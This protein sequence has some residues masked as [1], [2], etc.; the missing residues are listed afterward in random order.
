L[1]KIIACLGIVLTLSISVN[2]Y[3]FQSAIDW[4]EAWLEQMLTTSLVERIYKESG[5][6][7][8][9]E[10]V[11]KLVENEFRYEVVT[12]TNENDS[13]V[14]EGSAAISVDGTIL[15]FTDGKYSGSK[16]D[17]PDNLVHWG[18]GQD[19]F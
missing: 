9:Y 5:A 2:V 7:V 8:S 15:Y 6:D 1:R 14:K 16:A 11:N 17:L 18:V 10:A 19:D 3:L 12:L 13:W 4:Q